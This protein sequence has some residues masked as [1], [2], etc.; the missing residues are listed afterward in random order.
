MVS[1]YSETW[2]NC[3]RHSKNFEKDAKKLLLKGLLP[4]NILLQNICKIYGRK[5]GIIRYITNAICRNIN[6]QSNKIVKVW[7]AFRYRNDL[8]IRENHIIFV[9]IM[10][11]HTD[12]KTDYQI[13]VRNVNKILTVSEKENYC[14][15]GNEKL[16]DV[17]INDITLCL[18]SNAS[19]LMETH[20]N[21]TWV[22]ISSVK[23]SGQG[24]ENRIVKTLCIALYVQVKGFIPIDE[25]P[26]EQFINGYP[27]DVREGVFTLCGSPT[28]LHHNV[29]MGCALDSGYGTKQGTIGPFFR[30]ESDPY[31]YLLTSAHVLLDP[32]QMKKLIID[33]EVH[34]GMFGTDTYQPPESISVEHNS[35][36]H[37]GKLEFAVYRKGGQNTP[38]MEVAL[39]R[40][41]KDRIPID[42]KFPSK[43]KCSLI[44][45]ILHMN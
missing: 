33:K 21:L 41:N 30:Y 44:L 11:T 20:T 38:G 10:E 4:D 34:Y 45:K 26:F 39:V 28:E 6:E 25:D 5:S 1:L 16:S 2:Q 42:G 19:K 14:I 32:E 13:Y 17:R 8:K 9:V 7:P 24:K 22:T 3:F 35:R 29:R 43:C 27:V 37:L 31:T 18:K 12:I 40:I 23:S 36:H 15:R